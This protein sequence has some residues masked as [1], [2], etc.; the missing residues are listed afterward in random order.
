MWNNMTV[1]EEHT[2]GT[3]LYTPSSWYT[4]GKFWY[5]LGCTLHPVDKHCF[6]VPKTVLNG[7]HTSSLFGM[8]DVPLFC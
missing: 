4:P 6:I 8:K 2:S 3:P 1:L 7:N 5:T